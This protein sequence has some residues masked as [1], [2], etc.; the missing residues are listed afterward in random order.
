MSTTYSL[1]EDIFRQITITDEDGAAVDISNASWEI[2]FGL[3][4]TKSNA[5]GD[6]GTLQ[7]TISGGGITKTDAANGVAQIH[8]EDTDTAF[9]IAGSYFAWVKA[10]NP[11]GYEWDVIKGELMVFAYSPMKDI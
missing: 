4:P 10:R 7:K 8:I 6:G 3:F 5:W 11:T 1:G 9:F 2:Y